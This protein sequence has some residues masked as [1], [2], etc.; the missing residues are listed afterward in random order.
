MKIKT[1]TL[2]YILTL[3][4]FGGLI[5]SAAFSSL[6]NTY[7][8]DSLWDGFQ[9]SHSHK[10]RAL[11]ALYSEIGYG[12]M[13]HNFKNYLIRHQPENADAVKS[14]LGGAKAAIALYRSLEL[15]QSEKEALTAVEANLAA[16]ENVLPVIEALIEKSQTVRS[17]DQQVKV[18]DEAALK[19]LRVLLE[20]GQLEHAGSTSRAEVVSQIR[21]ALGFGGMIHQFKNAILR[22]DKDALDRASEALNKANL[23]IEK[24]LAFDLNS[25]EL[26]AIRNIQNVLSNYSTKIHNAKKLDLQSMAVGEI[27]KLVQVD[28]E[29]ALLGFKTLDKQIIHLNEQAE[30]NL[31]QKLSLVISAQK[32]VL[33]LTIFTIMLFIVGGSWLLR[34]Q[35]LKPILTLTSTMKDIVKGEHEGEIAGVEKRDEIGDMARA[36][37][38]FHENM[39]LLE[40]TKAELYAANMSLEHRVKER[41]QALQNS[42]QRLKA[43]LETAV[44][45]IIIIDENGCI[46]S[47]NRA[48]EIM[49]GY[50]ANEV[51]NNNINLLMPESFK[52]FHNQ[53]I[54]NYLV[55][56]RNKA[57][58]HVRELEAQRKDG[59]IFPIHVSVSEVKSSEG[60]FFTGIIR[61]ISE[62][63]TFQQELQVSK[64]AAVKANAAKSE[65]VSGMSHELRTP[66]NAIMGFTQLLESN[67]SEP[68]TGNQKESVSEIKAAGEHLLSVINQIL[69]LNKIE[70]G[71]MPINLKQVAPSQAIQESLVLIAQKATEVDVELFDQVEYESLPDLLTD[72]VRFKQVLINLLS[73]AVKYNKVG[74][75]IVVDAEIINQKVRFSVL[76]T[77]KGIPLYRQSQIFLPFERLGHESGEIEGTGIGLSITKNIVTQMQGSIGFDSQEGEGSCFWF[78]LPVFQQQEKPSFNS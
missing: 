4:L 72:E 2:L 69:D 17:I 47:F 76:D 65:F 43:I 31:S 55:S 13:I 49:F 8:I 24:Y 63:K 33:Y 6:S 46:Q 28:D 30:E 60:V 74:G 26:L 48:A 16:Y 66:L 19:G 73:N 29:P 51:L 27:D 37:E 3:S 35:I 40:C 61:D 78:E 22:D 67:S 12:G 7:E 14:S 53:H 36:L 42:E 71:K 1:A 15:N 77:G 75:K 57:I 34:F 58:G 25:K 11:N 41:T 44:D 64:E 38:V 39:Y 50:T 32:Q 23:S 18:S 20:Q 45:A 21:R 68:L 59:E 10:A 56:G 70:A 9:T 54:Q 52:A 5:A 62:L